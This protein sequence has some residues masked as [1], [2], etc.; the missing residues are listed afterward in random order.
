MFLTLRL[1]VVVLC[2]WVVVV[3]VVVVVV[4]GI[5]FKLN[6]VNNVENFT[7]VEAAFSTVC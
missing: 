7:G 6:V 3:D 2:T 1:V 4:V 5:L